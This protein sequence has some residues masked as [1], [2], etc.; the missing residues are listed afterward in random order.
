[1][2]DLGHVPA[3][4]GPDVVHSQQL[5]WHTV[6][7]PLRGRSTGKSSEMVRERRAAGEKKGRKIEVTPWSLATF[8]RKCPEMYLQLL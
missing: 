5:S 3:R 4:T 7:Q 8:V 1:M 2:P 6:T